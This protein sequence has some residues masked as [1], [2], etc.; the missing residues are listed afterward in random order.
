[1]FN[2]SHETKILSYLS[3]LGADLFG[4]ADLTQA[5]NV[6]LL[7]YGDAWEAYP[8]A[9]SMGLYFPRQVVNEL[10]VGPTHTYLRY[11]D[12]LNAR[13]DD[14][15]MRLAN[16]LEEQ[17]YRSFPIP[18]SQ[19]VGEDKLASIFSHRL[20]ASLAGLGWIGRSSCLINPKVGP[21]LRLA[22]VLTQAPLTPGTPLASGCPE[23]C[24]SCRDHCPAHAIKGV[25]FAPGQP[26]EMRLD[27]PACSKW[28]AETRH[29]FGKQVC[30]ICLAV[31][32]IGM[33]TP[34]STEKF[35]TF[36]K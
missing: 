24:T 32:P 17:G 8:R 7:E 28:L 21:R 19:R 18:A 36:I 27:A 29:S 4:V 3:A 12:V 35:E 11:Y 26:L 9:V 25:R 14:M 10:L 33:K 31:C 15:A 20:A 6:L 22:T 2:A 1:M 13:L 16:F 34:D 5:K 30:G 23:H